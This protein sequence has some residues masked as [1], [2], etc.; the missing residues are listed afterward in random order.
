[1]NTN[2]INDSV[3]HMDLA[4]VGACRRHDQFP[5]RLSALMSAAQA[6]PPKH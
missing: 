1:M 6:A 4:N 5:W 2:I 3:R